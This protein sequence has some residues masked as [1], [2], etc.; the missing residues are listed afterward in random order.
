VIEFN[1]KVG[2]HKVQYTDGDVKW[3]NMDSFTKLREISKS[4]LSPEG[5]FV[6]QL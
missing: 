4:E 3:Y 1:E 5:E 2:K 6:S